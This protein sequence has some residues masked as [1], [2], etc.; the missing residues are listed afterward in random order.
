MPN[1]L[2]GAVECIDEN[3]MLTKVT[4][5]QDV[6]WTLRKMPDI[7]TE[8]VNISI[9]SG[10]ETVRAANELLQQLAELRTMLEEEESGV[11]KAEVATA[12]ELLLERERW[13]LHPKGTKGSKGRH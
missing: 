2:R 9:T 11:R 8:L 3:T 7:S 5:M 1:A 12:S 4:H 6:A 13:N 10:T